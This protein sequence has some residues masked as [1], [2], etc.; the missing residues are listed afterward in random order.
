MAASRLKR[1]LP[2][3]TRA[4]AES[5][6]GPFQRGPRTVERMLSTL[7]GPLACR[8]DG[9]CLPIS[10]AR[11]EAPGDELSEQDGRPLHAFAL[12]QRPRGGGGRGGAALLLA[13]V[14]VGAAF[15]GGVHY[16][17]V[18]LTRRSPALRAI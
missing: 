14:G 10:R 5:K 4:E 16:Q 8:F 18:S 15:A 17:S 3:R 1:A 12:Y 6:A 11:A 9:L 2:G 7:I 13:A